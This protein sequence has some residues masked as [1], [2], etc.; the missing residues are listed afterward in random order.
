MT[1]QRLHQKQAC[2]ADLRVVGHDQDI[3]EERGNAGPVLGGL[4]ECLA[5]GAAGIG[6]EQDGAAA[7]QQL[8]S[9]VM[10]PPSDNVA[11]T[12]GSR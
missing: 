6:G 5:V 2:L 10:L 3:V 9:Q 1:F 11:W 7:R 8:L 12:I 4:G